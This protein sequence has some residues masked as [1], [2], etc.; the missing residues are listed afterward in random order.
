MVFLRIKKIKGNDYGYIVENEWKASK[1]LKGAKQGSRQKVKGYL[2]KVLNVEQKNDVKF[3]EHFKIASLHEYIEGN[4]A[5][6]IIKDIIDWNLHKF[7]V[8]NDVLIDLEGM[9]VQ[10]KNRDVVLMMNNG[11][12]CGITLKSLIE[13]KPEDEHRDGYRL[14]RAFIEA[15]IAIPQEVFIG[16][17]GKMHKAEKQKSDF[18]W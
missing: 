15:G 10:K 16:L 8:D 2:G 3:E 4:E 1:S 14:A 13:F 5:R 17:F 9:K 6:K 18:A 12:M 7:D 11:L